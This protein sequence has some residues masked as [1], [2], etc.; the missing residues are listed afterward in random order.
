MKKELIRFISD[1]QYAI[2]RNRDWLDEMEQKLEYLE[3]YIEDEVE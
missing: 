3:D 1:I 2:S